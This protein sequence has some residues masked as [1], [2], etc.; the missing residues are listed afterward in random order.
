MRSISQ[1]G[2]AT[3]IYIT[4]GCSFRLVS[5]SYCKFGP[6][7]HSCK[8]YFCQAGF[9]ILTHSI[10]GLLGPC[11]SENNNVGIAALPESNGLFG[12]K[13]S[14]GLYALQQLTFCKFFMINNLKALFFK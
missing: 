6:D 7:I 14:P 10:W 4:A 11:F 13:V 9:D 5:C 12:R 1:G 2:L 3:G 8:I